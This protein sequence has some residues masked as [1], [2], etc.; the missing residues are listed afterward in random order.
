MLKSEFL[1]SVLVILVKLICNSILESEIATLI[2]FLLT[3]LKKKKV[4]NSTLEMHTANEADYTDASSSVS[5]LPKF[6]M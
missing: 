1:I 4:L 5:K 3:C 2:Y 6:T